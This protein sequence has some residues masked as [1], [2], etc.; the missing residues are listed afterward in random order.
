MHDAVCRLPRIPP[1]KPSEKVSD[2]TRCTLAGRRK[3]S[4]LSRS[5][6]R[7]PAQFTVGATLKHLF[8]QSQRDCLIIR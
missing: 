8:G 5:V 2:A 4:H 6:F 1:L 3:I 7:I